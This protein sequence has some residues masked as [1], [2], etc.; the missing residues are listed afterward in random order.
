MDTSIDNAFYVFNQDNSYI[1]YGYDEEIGSYTMTIDHNEE[2]IN[3][4][5][6]VSEQEQHFSEIDVKRAKKARYIQERL[7]F[8]SDLDLAKG[9]E[10]GNIQDCGFDWRHIKIANE[11][12]G[13]SKHAIAGKSVQRKNKMP[14]KSSRMS[15]PPSIL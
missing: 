14:R 6:T 1:R 11:I 4:V 2:A 9:I 3:L 5:T 12:E 10:N 15:I 8:P 7:G 13:P